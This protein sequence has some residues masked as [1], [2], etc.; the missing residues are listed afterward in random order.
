[1]Q[2]ARGAVAPNFGGDRMSQVREAMA[3]FQAAK[4]QLR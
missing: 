1:V 3:Q 4:A 2:L